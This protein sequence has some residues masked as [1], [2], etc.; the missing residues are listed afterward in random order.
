MEIGR[1][2]SGCNILLNIWLQHVYVNIKAHE[3]ACLPPPP[4]GD[5]QNY[6]YYDYESDD[7]V[8]ETIA[9]MMLSPTAH[10]LMPIEKFKSGMFDVQ[11][12][13]FDSVD[14]NLGV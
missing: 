13:Y 1:N 5:V 14:K 6:T 8:F 4:P 2:S 11:L 3:V 10:T 12:D 7:I 9:E